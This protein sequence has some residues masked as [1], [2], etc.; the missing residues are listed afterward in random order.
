MVVKELGIALLILSL[1][2]WELGWC[3]V[4]FLAR[5][6]EIGNA[7]VFSIFNVFSENMKQTIP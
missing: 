4:T 1:P 6:D 2:I 5:S 7:P 3:G